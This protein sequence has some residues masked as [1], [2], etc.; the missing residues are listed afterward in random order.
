MMERFNTTK[1]KD[2]QGFPCLSGYFR[3]ICGLKQYAAENL[4][5]KLFIITG[6][7]FSEPD[8]VYKMVEEMSVEEIKSLIV[9]HAL[10][11]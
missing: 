7:S 6:Y 10:E 8:E 9:L 2:K 11:Q 4:Y 1:H 3:R 5:I